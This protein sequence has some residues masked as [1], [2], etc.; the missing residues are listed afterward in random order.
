MFHWVL[1]TLSKILFKVIKK[2]HF[3]IVPVTFVFSLKGIVLPKLFSKWLL[4]TQHNS[5]KDLYS[6]VFEN[7][8]V[9]SVFEKNLRITK[10]KE[11]QG[12]FRTIDG[13]ILIKSFIMDVWQ[14]LKYDSCKQN[15]LEGCPKAVLINS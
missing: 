4:W 12:V 5:W 1:N 2:I 8:D 11:Y 10:Y 14:S 7:L 13:A 15:F 6:R 3:N 9:N